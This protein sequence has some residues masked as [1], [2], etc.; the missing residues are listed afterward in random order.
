MDASF[1]GL[2]IF[3]AV[4]EAGSFTLAAERLHLSRSA[5]SKAIARLEDHLATRL[6]HRTTRQ[7]SLTEAGSLF[8]EHCLR[9]LAEI[10]SAQALLA[11]DQ[12]TV[13]GWLRVSMPVL[14]GRLCVAPILL[15]WAQAHPKL[16]LS[17]SF[18]D[19]ILDL[20]ENGFDL[21]IRHGGFV[22]SDHLAARKLVPYDMVLCG[23]PAYLAQAGT[24]TTFADLATHQALV[25]Q[26][27]AH[28]SPWF[29]T[30]QNMPTPRFYFD[31]VQ[32]IAD[33]AIAGMG[34]ANLPY[35]LIKEALANG[36][37]QALPMPEPNSQLHFYALWQPTQ[38]LPL[39]IRAAVDLL[40]AELPQR[41]NG[42]AKP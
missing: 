24:P 20:H 8:Y 11:D 31:D 3:V 6:F 1:K 16:T 18:N 15:A 25:Y 5:V 23:S 2:T 41:V 36:Q 34:L 32:V 26:R 33:A 42:V 40:L 19:R 14:F 10:R 28:E 39:K 35:W 9:A 27:G 12:T 22:Q 30:L 13:K 7:Q 37:L 38:Y 4:V 17:L 29:P 21:V